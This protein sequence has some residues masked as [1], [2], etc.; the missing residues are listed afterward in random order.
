MNR[1]AAR[2]TPYAAPALWTVCAVFA[3]LTAAVTS[4][5][6]H[7]VWGVFAAGGYAALAL[8]SAMAARRTAPAASTAQAAA[9]R[10]GPPRRGPTPLLTGGLPLLGCASA[11]VAPL[12]VLAFTGGAQEEVHVVHR[13]GARLLTGGTPYLSP[14]QLVG[15]DYTAYNPYLPGMALFGVPHRLVGLDARFGFAAVFLVTLALSLRIATSRSIGHRTAVLTASPLIALPMAVGGDDLPVL[16]LVCLGLALAGRRGDGAAGWAGLVLG[17]ACT[18]KATAW[19]ALPVAAALL[20]VRAGRPAVL[21]LAGGAAPVLAAGL[22]LP[23]LV[24]GAGLTAN[25]IRYPL[26]LA[27]AA[28]PAAAPLPGRLLATLGPA[29]HL[30]AVAGLV[31]AALLIAGSLLLR[32]PRDASAAA[33]RLALGLLVAMALLPAS[34]FGYAVYPAVL[35]LWAHWRTFDAR[36]PE[37]AQPRQR[38]VAGRLLRLPGGPAAAAGRA[39]AH[40]AGHAAG[41]T[42]GRLAAAAASAATSPPGTPRRT[43]IPRHTWARFAL[44]AGRLMGSGRHLMGAGQRLAGSGRRLTGSGRRLMGSGQQGPEP[45]WEPGAGPHADRDER[46]SPAQGRDRDVRPRNRAP[47]PTR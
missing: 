22:V 14:D 43:G 3:A 12:L 34:R 42:G 11:A 9:C 35:A 7:R 5:P 45:E 46:L 40:P 19:P 41:P 30:C 15:A 26:G 21:R 25:A 4:L 17:A 29:G 1:T 24:D 31:L 39:A 38:P 28:S 13:A 8:A 47:V 23:A 18:L 36:R 6:P 37:P 32:P 33:L 16:G 10:A 44:R 2:R 20:A 27:E